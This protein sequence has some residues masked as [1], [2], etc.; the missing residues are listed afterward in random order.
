MHTLLVKI[1]QLSSLKKEQITLAD[2][3]NVVSDIF[4]KPLKIIKITNRKPPFNYSP[5]LRELLRPSHN[6]LLLQK[7]HSRPQRHLSLLA[8]G[9]GT[10]KNG[11]SGDT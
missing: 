2:L 10:M 1:C 4:T 9:L 6:P 5:S 7:R 3:R 11:S 8:L